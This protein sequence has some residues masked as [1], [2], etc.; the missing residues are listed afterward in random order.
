MGKNKKDL[1][2]AE[3]FAI[4]YCNPEDSE[5]ISD[6]DRHARQS[7]WALLQ[8]IKHLEEQKCV[9]EECGSEVEEKQ[10]EEA[11][12]EAEKI[13]SEQP[14]TSVI[15]KLNDISEN[16]KQLIKS[17]TKTVAGA[18]V[19]AATS[20]TA[21]AAAVTPTL[22]AATTTFF[23]EAGQKIAAIGTA[24]LMSIGSGAYF[25]AKTVKTEGIEIAVVTEQ[26]YGVFSA[27]NGFTELAFGTEIFESVVE[28]AE[29]GYGDI[30]GKPASG[31]SEGVQG[32]ATSGGG[33]TPIDIGI[34]NSP[35]EKPPTATDISGDKTIILEKDTPVTP[36]GR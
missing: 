8:R 24:G 26:Q 34:E 1:S 36:T 32:G 20:Q 31:G 16:S 17:A 7:A 18:G 29:N 9:C 35:I 4:K 25:Q 12:E 11:V 15:E 6:L 3:D 22:T 28:Y 2:E 33:K 23:Q 14:D 30:A 13:K 10:E 27:I 5:I 19:V 21:S